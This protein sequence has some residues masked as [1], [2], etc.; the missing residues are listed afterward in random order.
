MATLDITD[1]TVVY[2]GERGQYRAVSTEES[3]AFVPVV[4]ASASVTP[5][6]GDGSRAEP[7]PRRGSRVG[8]NDPC[9]CKCGRKFKRCPNR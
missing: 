7:I 6:V 4:Y 3:R 9:P 8:R 5:I 2:D 1:A